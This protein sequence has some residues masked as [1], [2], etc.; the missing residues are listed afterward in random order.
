MTMNLIQA[1]AVAAE[2][3]DALAPACQRIEVAGSIRR[4]KTD[5]I[6]D[7]EVLA[8]SKP[9]Q[10][11]F[12]QPTI[13]PLIARVNVLRETGPV[14]YRYDKNGRKAAGEK[15]QRLLWNNVALDLFIVQPEQWGMAM[16]I[17]TGEAEF[18]H[19]LV[20]AQQ[21]GGAMPE[22]WK[23]EGFRLVRH[24]GT[25]DD[26]PTLALDTPTEEAVFAALKLPWIDPPERTE[27]RL[28]A[29]LRVKV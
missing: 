15:Y 10:I 12:G 14:T 3:V 22:L 8:I 9:R 19:R 7:V 21:F 28:I 13:W 24:I 17:R 11:A 27:A 1:Q 16:V 23:C 26:A 5:D 25:H 20:T 2:I 6:K 29:E 18:S 4:K